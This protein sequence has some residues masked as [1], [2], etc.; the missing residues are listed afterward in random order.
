[1]THPSQKIPT[2]EKLAFGIGE[3]GNDLYWQ[4]FSSF[5]LF[6]YT[7]IFKIAPGAQA[8]AVAG[9]MFVIVRF[10]DGI[11]DV[12]VG[13]L[14]DRTNSRWGKF[15]PYLLFGA[16][17]FGV[18][19]VV[20]FTTPDLGPTGK[21]IYAYATYTILMMVYSAVA[22][23]QNS[24]LGVMSGDSLERTSLSKYKFTFAFLASAVVQYA[25]FP[26][27]A[28][29]GRGNQAL[30]FQRT[31]LCY[32]ICAVVFFIF[33][34]SFIKERVSPPREQKPRLKDDFRDLA[35]NIPWLVLCVTTLASILSIATRSQ[36]TIYYFKYYVRSWDF[37]TV[38]WG[39][40]HI[41]YQALFGDF[42]VLGTVVTI[43]GT[44]MVPFFSRLLGKRVLYCI[45]IGS[46]G[47]FTLAF[48][49]VPPTQVGLIFLLQV[50]VSIT[51]G[52]TSAVL[53]AMYADCADFSEWVN[54]RRATALV[55]SAA[56]FCQK[57]G[58]SFGGLV[59]GW[60]LTKF[61]Y[62]ADTNLSPNT[63]HGIL[64]INCVI[65]AGFAFLAAVLVL[66]Y[67]LN[68]SKLK[69]IEADLQARRTA[70]A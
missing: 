47:F 36:T 42:L 23:P 19:G 8:A 1:M 5:L 41:G 29:F 12:I 58:W 68:E 9:L 3:F 24:L 2:G 4:F 69:V 66:F 54:S 63:L 13:L 50:L 65:P 38:F 60:L 21:L 55:F 64:V 31:L 25:T 70:A 51:L 35:R 46:S 28:H 52:P 61:G 53:W 45:L 43:L 18:A 32:A 56:I 39:V 20:A 33:S 44:W 10:W 15:R 11:F 6:F 62:V 59:P 26:L 27:A 49:F 57:V 16:V 37:N 22:I 30:G 48:Y 34:F 40:H 14:A 17:P 7:D 67:G